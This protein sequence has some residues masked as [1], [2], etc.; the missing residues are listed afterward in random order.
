LNTLLI[1]FTYFPKLM[2]RSPLIPSA[3][4][5]PAGVDISTN[6]ICKHGSG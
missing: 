5:D 6:P 4:P 1:L 3:G 2:R